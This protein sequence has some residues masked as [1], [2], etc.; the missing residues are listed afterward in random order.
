MNQTAELACPHLTGRDDR[1]SAAI[2]EEFDTI[3]PDS[4][5]VSSF[6]TARQILRNRE[7]KQAMMNGDRFPVSDPSQL[8]VFFLD[9][10]LHRKKRAALA[11]FFSPK[12]IA[13]LYRPLIDR[14]TEKLVGELRRTGRMQLD[15]ASWLLAVAVAAEIVGLKETPSTAMASRIE[16]IVKHGE[17]PGMPWAR[18]LHASAMSQFRTLLFYV[19]DVRPAIKA[20]RKERANDIISQLLDDG[21]SNVMILV[22]CMVYAT[23]GMTTTREFITMA[24][25][26]FFDNPELREAYVNG[27][28]AEQIAIL[29]EVLRLEPVGGYL[30]RRA[31]EEAPEGFETGTTYALNVREA[32]WDEAVA[33]ACPFAIDPSRAKRMKEVGSYMAFGDGMH[34]CPGAQVALHETRVFL[35][36]LFRVPGLQLETTPRLQWNRAMMSYELRD[37]WV[38]CPVG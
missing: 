5:R 35:D 19:S 11:K 28:E 8:P 14:E 24:A 9:G 16:E 30:Y 32:N 2:A 27:S 4:Q 3:Q 37:T 20:R 25:W 1:K 26:H 15:Q 18:K 10:E 29:E 7:F 34:R 38:S 33:G 12:A 17:Y 22:E 36:A 6:A 13:S 21:F 31:D 23:A